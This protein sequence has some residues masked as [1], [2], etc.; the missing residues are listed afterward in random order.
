MARGQVIQGYNA[1]GAD[2]QKVVLSVLGITDINQVPNE[3]LNQALQAVN[4]AKSFSAPA[5]AGAGAG[6][7]F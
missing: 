4:Q 3:K 6:N 5:P 1:L 2:V 7:P